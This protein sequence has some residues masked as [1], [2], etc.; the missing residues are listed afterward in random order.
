[1]DSDE[2]KQ[3]CL[4]LDHEG[5]AAMQ[6]TSR[7]LKALYAEASAKGALRSGATVKRT[8]AVIEEEASAFVLK[9]VNSVAPIAQDIDAFAQ[10]KA[11]LSANFRSWGRD[12]EKA[13]ELTTSGA[14]S[15]MQSVSKAAQDLF[16]S[17][18]ARIERELDIHRFSFTKPTRGMMAESLR[19][20]L[21]APLPEVPAAR[22]ANRGGK[23]L[24]KHWDAMWAAVSV[25]HITGNRT[26]RGC[27]CS[28]GNR[29]VA[30]GGCRANNRAESHIGV[31]G[32]GERADHGDRTCT[33]G[34]LCGGGKS[35]SGQAEDWQ[36]ANQILDHVNFS[37]SFLSWCISYLSGV[38]SLEHRTTFDSG[39]SP[40]SSTPIWVAF[41][42]VID[43]WRQ[44]PA[45]TELS[46]SLVPSFMQQAEVRTLAGQ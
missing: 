32:H 27:G 3:V 46:A 1:M 10:V 20:R 31:L 14:G 37:R 25:N 40:F 2:R 36:G 43:R 7:R 45:A 12:V 23:P 13:V 15:N 21:N 33:R 5:E 26:C 44:A 41:W 39:S 22:P 35:S 19:Q 4:I 17:A 29:P 24:A 6:A 34:R 9:S 18:K 16:L 30:G 11:R 42:R 8:V 38:L 28:H